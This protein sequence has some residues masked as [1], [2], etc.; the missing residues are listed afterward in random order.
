MSLLSVGAIDYQTNPE[1]F[2]E[3]EAPCPRIILEYE[4]RRSGAVRQLL[5]HSRIN[6]IVKNLQSN[7]LVL[8]NLALSGT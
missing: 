3:G 4:G 6:F 7:R 8:H 1:L 2:V 5:G